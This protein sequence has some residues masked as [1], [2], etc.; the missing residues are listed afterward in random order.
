M[1]QEDCKDNLSQQL[2]SHTNKSDNMSEYAA[3]NNNATPCFT[4][5]PDHHF[6]KTG[7]FS[8]PKKRVL[9]RKSSRSPARSLSHTKGVFSDN[10]SEQP[11][12]PSTMLGV[13]SPHKY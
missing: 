4:G 12:R 5:L 8:E 9:A 2:I 10:I 11:N 3:V 1:L 6:S 7:G 13:Y